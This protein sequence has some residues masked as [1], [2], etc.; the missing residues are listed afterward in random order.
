MR[1]SVVL[2]L[3]GAVATSACGSESVPPSV[4][5]SILSSTALSGVLGADGLVRADSLRQSRAGSLEFVEYTGYTEK[6]DSGVVTYF[7]REASC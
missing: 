3:T 4:T 1:R 2:I 6:L 7:F 5:E